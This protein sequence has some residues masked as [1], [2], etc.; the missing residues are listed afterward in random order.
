M[1]IYIYIYIYIYT[2]ICKSR[3]LDEQYGLDKWIGGPDETGRW[4]DGGELADVLVFNDVNN[5]AILPIDVE[6]YR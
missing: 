1:N 2:Y 5:R 4:V 6:N 3:R